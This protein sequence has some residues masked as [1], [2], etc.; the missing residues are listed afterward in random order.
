MSIISPR[1]YDGEL[2]VLL[3]SRH[4]IRKTTLQVCVLCVCMAYD[5]T[6]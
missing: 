3:T 5:M 6:F 2:P 1:K 4:I